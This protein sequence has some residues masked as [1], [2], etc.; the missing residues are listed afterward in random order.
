MA[1]KKQH[2]REDAYE[3]LKTLNS[4]QLVAAGINDCQRDIVLEYLNTLKYTF[5]EQRDNY[6]AA[7]G[8]ELHTANN[9]LVIVTTEKENTCKYCLDVSY[10]KICEYHKIPYVIRIK[11]KPIPPEAKTYFGIYYELNT[12][13]KRLHCT[14]PGHLE[15]VILPS[16]ADIT[17]TQRNIYYARITGSVRNNIFKLEN[18]RYLLINTVDRYTDFSSLIHLKHLVCVKGMYD[19]ITLPTGIEKCDISQ[20]HITNLLKCK[21][22]ID[23]NINEASR[24]NIL[25]VFALPNVES[26]TIVD[27]FSET[28]SQG[29]QVPFMSLRTMSTKLRYINIQLSPIEYNNGTL[30]YDLH[31]YCCTPCEIH[32]AGAQTV[33]ISGLAEYVGVV[34]TNIVY[35]NAPYVK[36]VQLHD[37]D[38]C[39]LYAA[40]IEN[41]ILRNIRILRTVPLDNLRTMK[42]DKHMPEAPNL[43]SLRYDGSVVKELDVCKYPVLEEFLSWKPVNMLYI[44]NCIQKIIN[45]KTSIMI[46][47]GKIN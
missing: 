21:Q 12:S 15:V 5:Y 19:T 32:I 35:V 18:L 29:S 13:G 4:L 27:Y 17:E 2:T 37:I 45:V 42:T 6:D 28:W 30:I 23:I 11:T 47:H 14:I 46:C 41:L 31:V 8:C 36:K 44:S 38:T 40:N 7:A 20:L 33:V 1:N 24:G 25:D 26:I 16:D 34:S 39:L 43:K 9:R 22:I 3:R 10:I